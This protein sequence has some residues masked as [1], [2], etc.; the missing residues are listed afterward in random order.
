[1]QGHH[2]QNLVHSNRMPKDRT[3]KV[4]K[5]SCDKAKVLC[6]DFGKYINS[7]Q[8]AALPIPSRYLVQTNFIVFADSHIKSLLGFLVPI[9]NPSTKSQYTV[10]D[11]PELL[12]RFV[13]KTLLHLWVVQKQTNFLPTSF[14]RKLLIFSQ[15]F[16]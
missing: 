16:A 9:L 5:A 4:Y 8:T 12:K 3:A 10:K 2:F 7:K 13:S 11:L 1:M 14:L 15:S 6:M